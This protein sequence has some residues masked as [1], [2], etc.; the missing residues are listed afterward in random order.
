MEEFCKNLGLKTVP[1]I[2]YSFDASALNL[3]SDPQ[4]SDVVK[5]M[6]KLSTAESTK[7]KIAREGIVVRLLENPNVS[8]KV[9]NPIFALEYDE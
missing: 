3:G 2:Y 4:V 1:V 9:I 6:V 7:A 5:A 8:F